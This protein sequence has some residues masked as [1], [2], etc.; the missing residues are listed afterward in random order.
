ME[1]A[2]LD[3]AALAELVAI[4]KRMVNESGNPVGFN[5]DAWTVD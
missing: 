1:A 4:V 3:T 2:P 5:A